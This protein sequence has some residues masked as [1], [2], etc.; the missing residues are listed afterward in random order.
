MP[1][2]PQEWVPPQQP[3]ELALGGRDQ[4]D[5]RELAIP[6]RVVLYDGLVGHAG[7][8]QE[9]LKLLELSLVLGSQNNGVRARWERPRAT[10]A[11]GVYHLGSEEASWEILSDD[12]VVG[13]G[14][15]GGP[16]GLT[17]KVES[18]C[19]HD[20]SPSQPVKRQA[21]CSSRGSWPTAQA[22]RPRA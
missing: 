2:L 16:R 10:L 12:D 20:S 11:G 6:G 22:S 13:Q 18:S 14:I 5:G 15:V 1:L 4:P 8:L 19:P 9:P 7:S 17:V 3:L 21:R